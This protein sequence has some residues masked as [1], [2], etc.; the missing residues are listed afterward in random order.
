MNT[1]TVPVKSALSSKI[2]WSAG[3]TT[4][5]ASANEILNQVQPML[6]APYNHDIT[7]AI[8]VV[9]GLYTIIVRTFYTTAI[10]T[11]SAAKL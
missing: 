2:N 1:V 8:M 4:L 5:L 6:P 3:L 7:I 9:G 11:S 10:T